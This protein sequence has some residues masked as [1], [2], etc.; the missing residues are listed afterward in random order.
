MKLG[1]KEF[2]YNEELLKK[3]M[4]QYEN[5]LLKTSLLRV[6]FKYSE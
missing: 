4:D 2:G 1:Y 3:W 5:T 6:N